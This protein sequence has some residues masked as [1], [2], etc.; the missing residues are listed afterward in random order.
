MATNAPRVQACCRV[1]FAGDLERRPETRAAVKA[2]PEPMVSLTVTGG[3][4]AERSWP[5]FSQRAPWA[6]RVTQ[7]FW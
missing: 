4:V 3:V 7:M 2:S 5:S 6:P 1:S